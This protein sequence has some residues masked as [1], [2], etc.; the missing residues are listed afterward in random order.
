MFE[1]L[2]IGV[3]LEMRPVESV[4]WLTSEGRWWS[5]GL[6]GLSLAREGDQL[7]SIVHRQLMDLRMAFAVLDSQDPTDRKCLG[8]G[9]QISPALDSNSVPP[10][11]PYQL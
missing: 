9:G 2:R 11:Q 4:D 5:I 8:E 6:R 3:H 7:A 1:A 10:A